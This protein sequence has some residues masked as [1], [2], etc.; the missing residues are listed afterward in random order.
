MSANLILSLPGLIL[1]AIQEFLW[2]FHKKGCPEAAEMLKI[3][4][5][6]VPSL[7]THINNRI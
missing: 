1:Q 2:L 6:V 3:F 7:K 4:C 5:T